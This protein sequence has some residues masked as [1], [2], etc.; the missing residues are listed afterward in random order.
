MA[1]R[2]LQCTRFIDAIGG[3]KIG[4]AKSPIGANLPVGVDQNALHAKGANINKSAVCHL[5]NEI[6]GALWA[7]A[8]GSQY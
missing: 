4:I 6:I 5:F 8:I 1:K 3:A 7:V 2:R